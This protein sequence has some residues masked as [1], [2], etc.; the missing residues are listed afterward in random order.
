MIQNGPMDT[1]AS[2]D[3]AQLADEATTQRWADEAIEKVGAKGPSDM[4]KVSDQT[5]R[6]TGGGRLQMVLMNPGFLLES[7]IMPRV[8][9]LPRTRARAFPAK[10]ARSDVIG[11]DRTQGRG[12]I[13]G[14]AMGQT[15]TRHT[16]SVD[17]RLEVQ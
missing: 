11:R 6:G 1:L 9:F 15:F 5:S 13:S 17:G 4:G 2:Y 7:R 16:T 12:T 8:S 10:Q 3:R 14:Q